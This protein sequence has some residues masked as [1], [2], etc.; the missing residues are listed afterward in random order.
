MTTYRIV[1]FFQNCPALNGQTIKEGLTLEEA[2]EHCE[3][4]ETSSRTETTQSELTRLHGA[5]FDGYREE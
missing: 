5:W 2:Q 3:A 4:P 1:R